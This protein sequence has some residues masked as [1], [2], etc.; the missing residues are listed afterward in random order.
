MEIKKIGWPVYALASLWFLPLLIYEG[1]HYR[2]SADAL[3][4]EYGKNL[5]AEASRH[6]PSLVIT[7]NENAYFV[8]RYIQ[9][10]AFAYNNVTIISPSLF[11][12]P[13]YLKKIQDQAPDFLLP[14]AATIWQKR[15][16]DYL[17]DLLEP[18]I[19]RYE[20]LV[21]SGFQEAKQFQ[22][23]YLGLG[24][25]LKAGAG[26]IFDP[27]FRPIISTASFN[28]LNLE[29]Q[30]FSKRFLYAQYSHY[31]LAKAQD[32]YVK[33]DFKAARVLSEDAL[34]VVPYAFPALQN[35]CKLSENKDARCAPENI[36]KIRSE[37]IGVF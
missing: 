29:P 23:Q 1:I 33:G 24:R 15:E 2:E 6:K 34:K 16:M 13:W 36:E 27:K 19:D 11:F 30:K 18:N 14:N 5:L 22:L 25:I 10:T 32:A 28:W 7:E 3:F 8:A 12:D 17:R 26:I 21:S 31:F 4:A 9:E 35:I 20:I 37:A